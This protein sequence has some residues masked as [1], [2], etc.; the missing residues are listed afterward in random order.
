M[1]FAQS[2]PR[3]VHRPVQDVEHVRA[4]LAV[5]LCRREEQPRLS[6]HASSLFYPRLQTGG[7]A[8]VNAGSR[9]PL[10]NENQSEHGEQQQHADRRPSTRDS[11]RRR[12]G[13]LS[14][15][16][17]AMP[18]ASKLLRYARSQKV[19]TRLANGH[20]ALLGRTP[21]TARCA[22]GRTTSASPVHTAG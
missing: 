11:A 5:V 1:S 21:R 15:L 19:G 16:S 6:R 13:H 14:A 22:P 8:C 20:G 17:Y 7:N 10:K 4:R 3:R 18:F 2:L 9:W 12:Y